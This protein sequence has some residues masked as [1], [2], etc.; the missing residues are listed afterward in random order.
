MASS[1]KPSKKATLQMPSIH[2][3]EPS[4]P[5]TP[6]VR[7]LI[8]GID[9]EV[10]EQAE[11]LAKLFKKTITA[12]RN[13]RDQSKKINHSGAVVQLR[14][15]TTYHDIVMEINPL[16]VAFRR[17]INMTY[18]ESI[19][20]NSPVFIR[21]VRSALEKARL[22]HSSSSNLQIAPFTLW[23]IKAHAETHHLL[24][25]LRIAIIPEIGHLDDSDFREILAELRSYEDLKKYAKEH[26]GLERI[27][28]ICENYAQSHGHGDYL[29]ELIYSLQESYSPPSSR[30]PP[31]E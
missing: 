29:N 26:P 20:T 9:K 28:A 5:S 8:E 27:L 12:L 22:T 23:E 19:V 7:P 24:K 11:K 31:Q 13:I 30:R 15:I 17:V 2:V 25:D 14:Q 10:E 4:P 16:A 3:V 21:A 1:G 6:A 18:G